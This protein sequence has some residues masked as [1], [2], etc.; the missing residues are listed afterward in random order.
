MFTLYFTKPHF[1]STLVSPTGEPALQ[2]SFQRTDV[3]V[4]QLCAKVITQQNVGVNLV[5]RDERAWPT[6]V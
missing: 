6:G 3:R 4:G 1:I 2:L 5:L